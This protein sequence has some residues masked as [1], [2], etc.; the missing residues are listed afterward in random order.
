MA[1]VSELIE[2]WL[3]DDY[4]YI[5]VN[6]RRITEQINIIYRDKSYAGIP[7]SRIR[8]SSPKNEQ[9][10]S[11]IQDLIYRG[12]MEPENKYNFDDDEKK[13]LSLETN[14]RGTFFSN[15]IPEHFLISKKNIDSREQIICSIFPYGY[16]SHISAMR[17]YG[18]TDRLPKE[19]YYTALS[20]EQWKKRSLIE[21]TT[22]MGNNIKANEFIPTYPRNEIYFGR[23]L[24]VTSKEINSLPLENSLGVRVQNVGELFNSMF[25]KTD[26]CG[27]QQHVI[28]VFKEH[29]DSVKNTVIKYVDRFGSKIDKARIGFMYSRVLDV[30]SEIIEKWKIESQKTRGSSKKLFS[31]A[32]FC[33]AYC[34]EWNLSL[35]TH[36]E[37]FSDAFDS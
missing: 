1:S 9:I 7:A 10:A 28:D 12:V 2:K 18:I 27:G 3:L 24:I 36:I 16:I 4:P 5:A 15:R 14:I 26:Y 30:E 22:R 34:E 21:I 8:N 13:F 31:N 11:T 6:K 20:K 37:G 29:G 25:S 35:N 32:P 17:W 33:S 23:R 19:V